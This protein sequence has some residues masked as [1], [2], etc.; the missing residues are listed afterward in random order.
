MKFYFSL[1]LKRLKRKIKELGLSPSL[2]FI[3]SFLLFIAFSEYL[4]Y[5]TEYAAWVYCLLASSFLFQLNEKERNK[6]LQLLFS[7]KEYFQIRIIENAI[8]ALPFM[9]YLAYQS[10]FFPMLLLLVVSLLLGI[11]NNSS[12]INYPIPTPFKKFPFEYIIG[13]RKAYLFLLLAY[14]LTY[15][16]IQVANFNLGLFALVLLFLLGMSFYLK[17]EREYYTWIYT[18]DTQQFIKHKIF[19]GL[20]CSSLLS[21]P[22]CLALAYFYPE[23]LIFI[24]AIQGLGYLFLSSMILAKY[25]AFPNEIGLPQSIL[26]AL[27]FSFPPL[28]LIIIPIFYSQAKRNLDSIL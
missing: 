24:I 2:G 9:L 8:I 12:S 18:F 11:F 26:Y 7:K 16:S 19:T 1:Q 3:L 27:T 17:P 21:V 28:I 13:F 4:F 6:E 22:I 20:I 5:K 14:F 23:K 25:S 10:A 15:K